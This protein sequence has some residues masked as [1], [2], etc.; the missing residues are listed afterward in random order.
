MQR[1]S[2]GVDGDRVGRPYRLGEFSLEGVD[3]RP[4][5]RDHIA[6]EDIRHQLRFQTG[7]VGRGQVDSHRGNDMAPDDTRTTAVRGTTLAAKRCAVCAASRPKTNHSCFWYS[8]LADKDAVAK[9][10]SKTIENLRWKV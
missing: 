3:V 4:E 10:A 7:H 8:Q 6:R 5:R 9:A 2:A 1:R